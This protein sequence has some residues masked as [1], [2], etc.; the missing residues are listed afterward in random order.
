MGGAGL[1]RPPAKAGDSGPVPGES[2]TA[3]HTSRRSSLQ[4]KEVRVRTAP[5]SAKNN[6]MIKKIYDA[7]RLIACLSL[8]LALGVF[9]FASETAPPDAVMMVPVEQTE[10]V[11]DGR[12]TLTKVFEVG[13]NVDPE[14]L[15]EDGLELNGFRYSLTSFTKEAFEKE[16]TKQVSKDQEATLSSKSADAAKAEA[17]TAMPDTIEYDEDGFTGILI[18]DS[19]SVTVSESGRSKKSGTSTKTKT[20]EFAYNDDSLIPNTISVDGKT[21]T[22]SS[23]TWSEGA[24][25][26][27]STIPNSY[28]ATVTYSRGW[29]TSVVNGYTATATYGGEVTKRETT[30]IR[31]RAVYTGESIVEDDQPDSTVGQAVMWTTV[32]VGGAALAVAGYMLLKKGKSGSGTSAG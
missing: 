26:E 18:R 4:K 32:G 20:Y 19:S 21:Y 2:K 1:Y 7:R 15:K 16:I 30:M 8:V 13:P 14:A 5:F 29:T 6:V 27:N 17:F 23:R 31:Y 11:I 10:Q 12:Q 28:I 25:G 22:M 3:A 9:A 24:F